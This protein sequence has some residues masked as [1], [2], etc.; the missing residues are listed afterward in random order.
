[1]TAT[2]PQ[3]T[4]T[5]LNVV[6][7]NDLIYDKRTFVPFADERDH[8]GRI[9]NS[10]QVSYMQLPPQKQYIK[11]NL[12]FRPKKDGSYKLEVADEVPRRWKESWK[13]SYQ[14]MQFNQ[15]PLPV[16]PP[17]VAVI[18]PGSPHKNREYFDQ[19]ETLEFKNLDDNVPQS[20]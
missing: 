4:P 10:E 19:M 20:L 16:A 5:P 17:E 1:M 7:Q 15:E 12:I 14:L 3:D 6:S 2:A 8:L 13:R 11:K 9:I 18:T